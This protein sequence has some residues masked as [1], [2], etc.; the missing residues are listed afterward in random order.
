MDDLTV[1]TESVPGCRQILQG[2]ERLIR[3]AWIG[4]KPAKSRSLVVKK[5]N[6]PSWYN[7]KDTLAATY[8]QGPYLHSGDNGEEGQC[9]PQEMAGAAQKPQGDSDMRGVDVQG[10]HLWP[11]LGQTWSRPEGSGVPRLWW[12]MQSHGCTKE[13][14]WVLWPMVEQAWRC[15]QHHLGAGSAR[16]RRS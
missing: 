10:F 3:W 14:W 6:I 7:A 8:V 16:G 5:G 1:T 13:I 2:L 4:F 11:C 12:Q 9:M 15:S